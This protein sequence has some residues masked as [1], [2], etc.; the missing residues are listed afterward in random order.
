VEADTIWPLA[1]V[2]VTVREPSAL[3]LIVVL[4]PDAPPPPPLPEPRPE[5]CAAFP[6]D[7][8]GRW[9]ASEDDEMDESPLM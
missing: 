4:S 8:D 9:V 5:D 7:R 6:L 1:F 3:V 2:T